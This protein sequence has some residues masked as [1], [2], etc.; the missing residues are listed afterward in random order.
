MLGYI[1]TLQRDFCTLKVFGV[2][3]AGPGIYTLLDI[4]FLFAPPFIT[5]CTILARETWVAVDMAGSRSSRPCFVV[6]PWNHIYSLR[7]RE[8]SSPNPAS[9][10]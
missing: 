10:L 4:K 7:A 6:E 5:R 8:N 3:T 9:Q 2:S 1:V